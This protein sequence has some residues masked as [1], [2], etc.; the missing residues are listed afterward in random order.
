M[1]AVLLFTAHPIHTE[2]VA[3][4]VGHA[5][6]LGAALGFGALLAYIS[7]VKQSVSRRHYLQLTSAVVLVW[8]AALAKEI[9]ITMVS[10]SVMPLV[11]SLLGYYAQKDLIDFRPIKVA[12]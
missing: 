10:H 11:P 2:A 1:V 6:L 4:I 5:E 8:T 12:T 7:A 3:G 9:G